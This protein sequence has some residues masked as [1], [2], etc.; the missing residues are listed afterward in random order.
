MDTEQTALTLVISPF[1]GYQSRYVAYCR[2]HGV[3]SPDEMWERDG[4]NANYM[5]WIGG[6]WREWDALTSHQGGHAQADHEAFD[7]WLNQEGT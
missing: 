1:A 6:K 7:A 2:A 3:S 4:S 5:A